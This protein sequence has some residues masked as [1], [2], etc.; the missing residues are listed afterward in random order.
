MQSAIDQ[1]N[2]S[3]TRVREIIAIHHFLD[4]QS[5]KVLDISDILRAALV[6]AVSA[7][8]YYVHEVVRIGM[9]EIHLGVRPEPNPSQN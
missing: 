7:L 3:I 9:I 8:D 2:I 5:T 4:S 1:F 6:L